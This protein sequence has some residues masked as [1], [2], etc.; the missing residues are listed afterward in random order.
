M[1]LKAAPQH[2]ASEQAV[3]HHGN[4]ALLGGSLSMVLKGGMRTGRKDAEGEGG[5]SCECCRQRKSAVYT[6][7]NCTEVTLHHPL[8]SL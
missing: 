3:R 1:K 8:P 7:I 2:T 4:A 5:R 6:H